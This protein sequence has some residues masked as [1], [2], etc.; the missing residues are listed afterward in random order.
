MH[1]D[2]MT[3]K[4][5]PRYWPFVSDVHRWL[6][7]SPRQLD[8]LNS[9]QIHIKA[10]HYWPFCEGNPPITG[11]FPSQNGHLCGALIYINMY[12]LLS[13]S[14]CWQT[15]VLRMMWDTITLLWRHWNGWIRC[16]YFFQHS[17]VFMISDILLI[18]RYYSNR[19][20]GHRNIS[21]QKSN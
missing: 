19:Q 10:P 3:W 11:G 13:W 16:G 18:R 1:D 15:V 20:T 17:L 7:H 21:W 5:L 4:N 6:M 2:V 8:E 12:L 14:S 9:K